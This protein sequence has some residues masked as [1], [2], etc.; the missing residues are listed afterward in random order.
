VLQ[1]GATQGFEPLR[2]AVLPA[3]ARYGICGTAADVHVSTGGSGGLNN[4]CMAVLDPGDVVAVERPTYAPA[5]KVFRAYGA[6]VVDVAC[7]ADGM[8]P[9]ALD[10]LLRARRLKL[11]YLLP[12]FQN[13]S[14]RTM[15]AARR[16][17]VAEILRR[18]D[19]LAIEDDVYG[20]LR[21][22]GT[23]VPALAAAAPERVV[24]LGSVSKLL[25]PAMRTGIAVLPPALLTTVLALKQ[26]I[27]MQTSTYTQALVT[28]FLT[29]GHAAG[30]VARLR[31]SYGERLDILDAALT[32]HLPEGY[33]W[34]R[35]DGGM[36]L[37]LEGPAT[38]DA[39]RALPAA[40]DAGVAYV[41][42]EAFHVTP[43]DGRR[44]LRLSFASLPAERID[45]GVRRL[46]AVLAGP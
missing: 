26:G 3:L 27:D 17:A 10:T 18:H 8:I 9:E 12:T 37:W 36:F 44:A 28:V 34:R 19:V 35:P 31:A 46:A 14:G 45:E 2:S 41:P 32:E 13:P 29:D 43:A 21:Y 25:A 22:S 15:P 6:E 42:G 39:G 33:A 38:L 23:P 16:V 30:H 40:L 4:V 20:A 7:D 1:Y 24:Y 11:V 5:V